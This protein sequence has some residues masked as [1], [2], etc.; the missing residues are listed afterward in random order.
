MSGYVED[1]LG[2]RTWVDSE[3]CRGFSK[4]MMTA[5]GTRQASVLCADISGEV[6]ME[7]DPERIDSNVIDR[8]VIFFFRFPFFKAISLKP[9]T[10]FFSIFFPFPPF[11]LDDSL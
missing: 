5:F 3:E 8:W 1:S 7:M 2:E 9:L 4:N 10:Q 6:E 11:F